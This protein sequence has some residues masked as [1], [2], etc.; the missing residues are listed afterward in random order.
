[1]MKPFW[2]RTL[3]LRAAH[4][5]A[6]DAYVED[7]LAQGVARRALDAYGIADLELDEATCKSYDCSHYKCS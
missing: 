2:P 4:L 5:H 7:L 1:M 3:H 6:R